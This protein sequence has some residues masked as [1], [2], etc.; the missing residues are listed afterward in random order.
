[1]LRKRGWEGKDS[2]RE[3]GRERT[4]TEKKGGR[5]REMERN[6]KKKSHR[7]GAIGKEGWM[8]EQA[9]KEV[10]RKAKEWEMQREKVGASQ[11]AGGKYRGRRNV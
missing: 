11:S 7:N 4:G 5:E 2:W 9:S 6:R 10:E 1:V 3:G 8:E